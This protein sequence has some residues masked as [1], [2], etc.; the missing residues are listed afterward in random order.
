MK[1]WIKAREKV[2]VWVFARLIHRK[3]LTE[4]G[5]KDDN[6]DESDVAECDVGVGD[7]SGLL[8]FL[9]LGPKPKPPT[10]PRPSPGRSEVSLYVCR[11][12]CVVGVA[13]RNP[14]V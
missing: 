11:L 8:R 2:N 4:S 7:V 10:V 14:Q 9:R 13:S 3:D 1:E 6:N 5:C 12:A